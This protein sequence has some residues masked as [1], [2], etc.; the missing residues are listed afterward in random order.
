M[1]F[2]KLNNSRDFSGPE[3]KTYIFLANSNGFGMP[4]SRKIAK[5]H[6]IIGNPVIL[7]QFTENAI[8]MGI[9]WDLWNWLI[10]SEMDIFKNLYIP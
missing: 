2:V 1:K 9:M 8:L 6:E 7:I 4:L 3:L 5:Y 10:F